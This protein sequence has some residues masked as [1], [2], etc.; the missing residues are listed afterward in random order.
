MVET[1]YGK[2]RLFWMIP[3][4]H[5][6]NRQNTLQSLQCGYILK[7]ADCFLSFLIPLQW[8][9]L[10]FNMARA[11]N[12]EIG[13]CITKL[14]VK[15]ELHTD[16]NTFWWFFTLSVCC[17]RRYPWYCQLR[18]KGHAVSTKAP[19]TCCSDLLFT[20]TKTWGWKCLFNI[21]LHKNIFC[22]WCCF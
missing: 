1:C 10:I 12:N 7:E 2:G 4:K 14:R 18:H 16:R 11:W 3:I 22:Y 15:S 6:W 17:E 19:P 20:T 5:R 13:A 21:L 8:W 9:M